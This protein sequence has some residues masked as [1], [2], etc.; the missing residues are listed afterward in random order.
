MPVQAQGC[1]F[2]LASCYR[3][4]TMI[5]PL[6]L[7]V[8]VVHEDGVTAFGVSPA[9]GRIRCERASDHMVSHVDTVMVVLRAVGSLELVHLE[10]PATKVLSIRCSGVIWTQILIP[11]VDGLSPATHTGLFCIKEGVETLS[12]APVVVVPDFVP[13][14]DLV[15]LFSAGAEEGQSR[16]NRPFRFRGV[17]LLRLAAA[18]ER[19]AESSDGE[20]EGRQTV[21]VVFAHA[22]SSGYCA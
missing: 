3:M 8:A 1:E 13:I 12:D 18:H 5:L 17:G 4:E 6:V 21:G 16:V 19:E 15:R 20:L 11:P 2:A 9:P 22:I 14:D 10:P 7:V